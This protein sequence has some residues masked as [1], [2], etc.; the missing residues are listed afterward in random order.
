MGF[1]WTIEE[2]NDA[3]PAT[4][5]N[6]LRNERVADLNPYAPLARKLKALQSRLHA[7]ANGINAILA[8]EEV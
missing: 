8:P 7:E 1:R 5:L 6:S 4:M 3:S 2:L